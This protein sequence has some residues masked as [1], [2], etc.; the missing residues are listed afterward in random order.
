[1]PDGYDL[2]THSQRSDG[3]LS[4]HELVNRAAER[5]IHCLSLTDHDTLAGVGEAANR[6][7]KLAMS[8]IPGVEISTSWNDRTVHVLGLGVRTDD[9]GLTGG[10]EDLRRRRAD[11][12]VAMTR[13][14]AAQGIDIE[15]AL[16]TWTGETSPTR[17]HFAR[18]LVR[19]GYAKDHKRAFKRFLRPGRPGY[20]K[21]TWAPLP[22]A[23]AWIRAAGGIAVLA[24][25]QH[26]ALTR[27]RRERLLGE[28][29]AA[30]GGGIEVVTGNA[31][32]AQIRDNAACARRYGLAASV[33]SDFH[34]PA[35]HW[36]D[37]G[38]LPC[39]PRD[40]VPVWQHWNH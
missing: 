5:G 25:P 34:G 20:I 14:F 35:Q 1:M 4:P 23:I 18:A 17:T 21:A 28:F 7:R 24:H 32:A 29:C 31:S 8:F 33:G 15:A 2:H 36:N 30:G 26:Y 27:T 40:L 9:P 13:A 22:D 19:A 11:R 38:R 16:G 10:L 3:T 37:L 39:L 6:A 12:A